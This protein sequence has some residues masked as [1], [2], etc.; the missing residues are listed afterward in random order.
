MD[1]IHKKIQKSIIQKK[2]QN[3]NY[4]MIKLKTCKIISLDEQK[5]L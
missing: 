4:E 3:Q 1:H 2:P 5:T